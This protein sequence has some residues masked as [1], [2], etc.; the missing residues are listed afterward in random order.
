MTGTW[1]LVDSGH[2]PPAES[3]AVDEAILESHAEGL[4]GDTLHFYVRSKP[5][6][7]IGYF[8]KVKEAVD[9]AECARRGVRLVRRRSGGSSIFTDP[10]QLI[11]AVVLPASAIGTGE[12]S[13]ASVC[14]PVARAISSLGFDA[15]HRPAND[16]EVDG[17]KISGSAQLRR[18][19]SALQHGTVLID[20]DVET[21]DAV[22]RSGDV[23]PSDRVTTLSRLTATKPSMD[24][25][26][27]AIAGEIARS[28]SVSYER[29]ELTAREQERIRELVDARYGRD[30]WNLKR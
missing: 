27:M 4:V 26:K 13:F 17:R 6:V 30:E 3:A 24:R 25:V 23:K 7:S 1:R 8:Q 16:I 10:G 18:R 28:F 11:Y 2:I 19:G 22:L 14:V 15:K 5:T 20:S 9:V 12:G 21:M 29:C